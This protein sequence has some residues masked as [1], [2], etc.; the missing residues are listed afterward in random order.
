M[1]EVAAT[2]LEEPLRPS[3]PSLIDVVTARPNGVDLVEAIHFHYLEDSF[4]K[5]IV[6]KPKDF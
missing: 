4:F 3:P 2:S 1:N 5:A 6:D